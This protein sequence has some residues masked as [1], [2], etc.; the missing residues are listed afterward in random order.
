MYGAPR[1]SE[2]LLAPFWLPLL[3]RCRPAWIATIEQTQDR[4]TMMILLISCGFTSMRVGSEDIPR[5]SV[6]GV[7]KPI[8]EQNVLKIT[9][10]SQEII[11][12]GSQAF[13]GEFFI[14]GAQF[15]LGALQ[16][17]SQSNT[18]RQFAHVFFCSESEIA[19]SLT[20]FLGNVM[21]NPVRSQRWKLFG[22]SPGGILMATNFER[23]RLESSVLIMGMIDF[24]LAHGAIFL[25]AQRNDL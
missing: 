17:R 9:S 8:S 15:R 13:F 21:A 25:R 11:F 3:W 10:S 20:P 2:R 5:Y 14:S 1:T 4:E 22:N 12:V 19:H 23:Q 6:F 18:A 24:D 16:R 7:A